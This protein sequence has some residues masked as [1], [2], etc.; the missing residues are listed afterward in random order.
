V[1]IGSLIALVPLAI[2]TVRLIKARRVML[3]D[4]IIVLVVFL[5]LWVLKVLE[6]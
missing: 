5:G 2:A 4:F 1:A 3:A 6:A